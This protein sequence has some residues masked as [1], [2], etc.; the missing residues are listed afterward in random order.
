MNVVLFFK[1]SIIEFNLYSAG[2]CLY[3]G[4][5]NGKDDY[6][7][8]MFMNKFKVLHFQGNA[9]KVAYGNSSFQYQR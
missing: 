3:S 5:K 7:P 9:A 1:F 6:F 8:R 4:L 2:Q